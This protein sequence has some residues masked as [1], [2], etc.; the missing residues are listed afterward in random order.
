MLQL[1]TTQQPLLGIMLQVVNLIM[2]LFTG[3]HILVRLVD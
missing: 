1:L 2:A 3:V